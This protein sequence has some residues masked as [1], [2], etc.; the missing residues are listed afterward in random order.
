MAIS[1]DVIPIEILTL[2]VKEMVAKGIQLNS[3]VR[4]NK[5]W[6][7]LTQSVIFQQISIDVDKPDRTCRMFLHSVTEPGKWV[8]HL[9]LQ[10]SPNLVNNLLNEIMMRS[11]NVETFECDCIDWKHFFGLLTTNGSW[12]LLKK[13]IP[14]VGLLKDPYNYERCCNHFGKSLIELHLKNM[15]FSNLKNFTQLRKLRVGKLSISLLSVIKIIG[16]DL[17]QLVNLDINFYEVVYAQKRD[18]FD[19]ITVSVKNS[20]IFSNIQSLALTNYSLCGEEELHL[21]KQFVNLKKLSISL[22]TLNEYINFGFLAWVST[23]AIYNC[24][25][26]VTNE[27]AFIKYLC[28]LQNCN[29]GKLIIDWTPFAYDSTLGNLYT[30][31]IISN[32][33]SFG[34]MDVTL[35]FCMK[36][37]L[38]EKIQKAKTIK[39]ESEVYFNQVDLRK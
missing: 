1:K 34:N 39:Y 6:F 11:P 14:L 27:I 21:L 10:G 19:E 31:A 5:Q 32:K 4:V 38:V 15:S 36:R 24:R 12:L 25:I 16:N 35:V 7:Y 29:K 26:K 20:C 17:P 23:L 30:R 18:T 8:K 2:I 13:L 3:C 9:K 33:T 28:G 22:V 37:N